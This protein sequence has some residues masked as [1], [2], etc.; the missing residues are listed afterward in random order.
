MHGGTIRRCDEIRGDLFA[1]TEGEITP[2]RGN[3]SRP[4]LSS[5]GARA[6]EAA[7]FREDLRIAQNLVGLHDVDLL[8]QR[9]LL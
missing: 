2:R 8:K 6:G 4:I 1:F 9:S 3:G 5:A 7:P